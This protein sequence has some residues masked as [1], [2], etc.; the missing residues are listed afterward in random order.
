[1]IE[2]PIV[3]EKDEVIGYKPREAVDLEN[4]IVRSASL[5]ITDSQGRV[6]LAQRKLTKR[7]DPGKW[8]EAVGGTVDGQDS[9]EE[10]VYREAE[11]EL[12]ITGVTFE[13]GPK[14]FIQGPPSHYFAQ[15]YKVTLDWPIERFVPQESEVEQVAW[16]DVDVL[17]RD[18]ATNPDKYIAALPGIVGLLTE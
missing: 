7:T 16:V 10:T 2:I 1:M 18:M 17:K 14:Q 12:G 5:W 6:L 15:W 3:N 11:E 9:Y 4:D 8:A 13:L